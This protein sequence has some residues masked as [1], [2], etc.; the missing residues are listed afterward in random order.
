M[1]TVANYDDVILH[2]AEKVVHADMGGSMNSWSD[3]DTEVVGFI[4]GIDSGTV[5]ADI[6]VCTND[7]RRKIVEANCAYEAAHAAEGK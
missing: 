5:F 2:L 3:I 7:V 1:T 6:N 4:Y